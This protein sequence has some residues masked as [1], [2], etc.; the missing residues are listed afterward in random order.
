[1]TQTRSGHFT[2]LDIQLFEANPALRPR[3]FSQR[4]LTASR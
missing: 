3:D 1:M 4:E 2:S